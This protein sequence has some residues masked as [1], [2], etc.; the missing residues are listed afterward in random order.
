MRANEGKLKFGA[1]DSQIEYDLTFSHLDPID[2]VSGIQGR[3][4]NLN[5]YHGEIDGDNGPK[6]K[7]A[8][9]VF[10]LDVDEYPKSW[11]VYDSLG[12]AYMKNGDK[13]LAIQNYEKSIELNP[14]NENGKMM[15]KRLLGK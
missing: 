9:E 1:E 11:N 7:E 8:I 4:K 15:L 5:L 2:E 13:E 10:K 12:E 3:L 14:D 6:T